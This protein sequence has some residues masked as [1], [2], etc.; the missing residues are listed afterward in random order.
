MPPQHCG[1]PETDLIRC[2]ARLR[3]PRIPEK[4]PKITEIVDSGHRPGCNSTLRPDHPRINK[5]RSYPLAQDNLAI[6]RTIANNEILKT[7]NRVSK[8]QA[9]TA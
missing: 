2:A 6:E 9:T 7:A 4:H 1:G 5:L 8:V 3:H